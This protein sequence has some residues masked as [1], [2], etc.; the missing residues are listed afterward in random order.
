[1]HPWDSPGDGIYCLQTN[2]P[3]FLFFDFLSSPIL[4]VPH[5][6]NLSLRLNVL[7]FFEFLPS[8]F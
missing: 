5:D 4:L 2:I 6:L 7:S 8:W 1:M 3:L